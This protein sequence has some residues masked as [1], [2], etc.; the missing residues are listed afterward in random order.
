MTAMRDFALEFRQV[1]ARYA[2]LR[3]E[4]ARIVDIDSQEPQAL[5]NAI[6]Q[7]RDCLDRIIHMNAEVSGLSRDWQEC[8]HRCPLALQDSIDRCAE[9]AKSE[10]TL[11]HELCCV[12][13]RRIQHTCDTLGQALGELKKGALF[14]NS[15]KPPK[16]NYPKFIDS[17]Y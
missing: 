7:N 13:T 9:E 17:M 14:I 16:Q 2:R 11:L 12:Q 6:L 15:L 1:G 5:V 8:R 3:E 10:A 4:L